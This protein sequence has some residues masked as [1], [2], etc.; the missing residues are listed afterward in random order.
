MR[1]DRAAAATVTR[2]SPKVAS[3]IANET[4]SED[5]CALAYIDRFHDTL[6]FDH[7]RKRWF[8]WTGS[9]WQ[10]DPTSRAF[11]YARTLSREISAAQSASVQ[12]GAGRA[13]FARGVE[14]LAQADQR[15][16]V[17]SD[18]WDG[19]PFLLG[20]P[21]GTVDLRSG[22]L[23]PA[24]REDMI[25]RL[26]AIAPA[27]TAECARWREFLAD[28]T[29]GDA[30]HIR[31]LQ[32]WLGYCLTGDTT[33]H[34]LA[35]LYGGGGNG[36]GVF[37]NTAKALLG[38]YAKA[39][40]MDVFMAAHGERHPEE[41]ASLRG[42]RMVTASETEEGRRW[43]EARVKTLTGGDPI[44]ARFMRENS[45][46]FK[47]TFKLTFSGNHAPA[48]QNLDDAIRRRFNILPF[49]RKPAKPDPDL[50]EKLRAEWPAILRWAIDGCLDWRANRLARPA[51]VREA[52]AE[53][54]S[55]QDVFTTWLEERCDVDPANTNK[56]EGSGRLFED[57]SSY[58]KS[59]GEPAGN[60]K[61]FGGR[62]RQKG[63]ERQQIRAINTK[64][65]RGLR[66]KDQAEGYNAG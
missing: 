62:L 51:A 52:T 18:A 20:T 7:D 59:V 8:V 66:L 43:A 2:L 46:E 24:R 65:Y 48:I 61:T 14:Q 15:I 45:F 38:D 60:I 64:G 55:E 21:S 11:D 30:G 54:F 53:Y 23:R 32:Q 6:R 26:T 33:E 22:E 39:A 28:A 40:A 56:F 25:T 42:A 4:F 31:F 5:S 1:T 50:E 63:F 9:R 16:A 19:D 3:L 49:N 29:G 58:A 57:W 12:K 27:E 36:K 10:E 44:R 41:L 47:P 13:A 34:A 35:F 17:T 37:M